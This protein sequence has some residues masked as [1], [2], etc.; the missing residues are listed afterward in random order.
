MRERLVTL[1]LALVPL[2]CS[3]AEPPR[4]SVL[5]YT[6]QVVLRGTLATAEEGSVRI[7]V[8]DDADEVYPLYSRRYALDHPAFERDGAELVLRFALDAR[9]RVKEAA[10]DGAATAVEACFEPRGLFAEAL[11]GEV[12]ERAGIAAHGEPVEVVL[13]SKVTIYD[14]RE[15]DDP[16]EDR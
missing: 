10:H 2:A 4:A 9:H 11:G 7:D 12:V 5:P 14:G 13:A 8:W 16:S 3:V 15:Y 6:G 1:G